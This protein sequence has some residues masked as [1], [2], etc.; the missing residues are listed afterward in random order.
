MAA[1]I[2]S[3]TGRRD[4]RQAMPE[5]LLEREDPGDQGLDV[6]VGH[7]RVR[8][9]GYLAPDAVS[10]RLDLLHEL[11]RSVLVALVFRG[12]CLIR[13]SDDLLVDG[14]ACGAS[15]LLHH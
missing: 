2:A 7:G 3:A 1:R 5:L 12:D 4:A 8:R 11:C 10:S 13:G 6:L 15:V 14:V 9:H